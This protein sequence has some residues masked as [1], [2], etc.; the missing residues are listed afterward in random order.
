MMLVERLRSFFAY[1]RSEPWP[2]AGSPAKK[3]SEAELADVAPANGEQLTVADVPTSPA[4]AADT[5][6]PFAEAEATWARWRERVRCFV[7]GAPFAP[8][9]DYKEVRAAALGHIPDS[10]FRADLDRMTIEDWSAVVIRSLPYPGWSKAKRLRKPP[11]GPPWA[12]FVG[13]HFLGFFQVMDVGE[14]ASRGG[15]RKDLEWLN[16][17]ARRPRALGPG[18]LI[19]E[20]QAG[21]ADL[22][23]PPSRVAVLRVG[24]DQFPSIAEALRPLVDSGSLAALVTDD[25]EAI[26]SYGPLP[27]VT[28]PA[29]VRAAGP[30]APERLQEEVLKRVKV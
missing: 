29:E 27:V 8:A 1:C 19:V 20:K 7:E 24:L 26:V 22:S 4:P 5:A 2:D 15:S 30:L 23:V 3:Y 6:D 12:M 14:L 9:I 13:L 21:L 25:A 11:V 16:K 17:L 28:L 18:L 10:L